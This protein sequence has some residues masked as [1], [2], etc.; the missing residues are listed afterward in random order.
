MTSY[1]S[2]TL[3]AWSQ[4][5]QQHDK[6]C[7]QYFISLVTVCAATWQ[8]MFPILYQL[9]HS[10]YSNMISCVPNTL[11]AWSQC[12]QQLDKLCSQCFISLVTVCTAT[13]RTVFPILYQLGHNVYSNMTNYVPNTSSAWS[14]CVQQHGE[15]CSQYFIS[16]S[17]CAQQHDKLCFQYFVSLVRVCTATWWSVFPIL[18]QLVTVCTA[19]WWTVFPI[20]YQLVTVCTAT[21]Q[22]VFPILYQLGHS[23]YSYLTNCVPNTLSAWS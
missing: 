18:Y 20:L 12:V 21:W 9:G 5:V 22:A 17:Q 8:A 16:L 3:S 10:V 15:L 7:F 4:C 1:V 2:N 19:T 6:L 23:V 14:Q 11:S 13:W